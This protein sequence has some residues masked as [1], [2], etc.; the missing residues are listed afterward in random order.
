MNTNFLKYRKFV[1]DSG[2]KHTVTAIG[3]KRG[4]VVSIGHNQYLKTHPVQKAHAEAVGQPQR[5]Y[6]H[7]E[8]D[9]LVRARSNIDTLLVFRFAKDGTIRNAKPCPICSLAIERAGIK[10]V[11]HS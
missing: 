8:I 2:G 11:I 5:Q 9:C 7:A 6:L 4:R 3:L 1:R 10:Q